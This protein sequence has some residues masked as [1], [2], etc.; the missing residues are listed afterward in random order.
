[1][2]H[3][4]DGQGGIGDELAQQS[5]RPKREQKTCACACGGQNQALRQ[6]LADQLEATGSERLANTYFALPCAGPNQQQVGKIGADDE[7]Q[8]PADP[9]EREQRPREFT[10]S[11]VGR[12]RFGG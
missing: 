7:Q 11:T 3:Q 9:E 10:M 6:Q 8:Q 4:R 12:T 2:G 1:M 5:G